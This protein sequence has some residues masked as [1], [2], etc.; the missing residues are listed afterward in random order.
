MCSLTIECAGLWLGVC[1]FLFLLWHPR[2]TLMCTC[3]SYHVAEA[4]RITCYAHCHTRCVCVCVRARAY[5]CMKKHVCVCVCV[6]VYA[7]VQNNHIRGRSSCPTRSTRTSLSRSEVFSTQ[8]SLRRL[9]ILTFHSGMAPTTP[10]S[11]GLT[12]PKRPTYLQKRPVLISDCQSH[13][14]SLAR[15]RALSVYLS[16]RS[17]ATGGRN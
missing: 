10:R 1:G 14:S 3:V 9:T 8:R 17:R 16:F 2:C 7:Y 11:A 4:M 15:A 6:C 13:S 12:I 5:V